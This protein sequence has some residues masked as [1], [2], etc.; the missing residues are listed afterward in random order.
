M[1]CDFFNMFF[2][3]FLRCPSGQVRDDDVDDDYDG[4]VMTMT[5]LIFIMSYARSWRFLFVHVVAY[6]F[7]CH[8]V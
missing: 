4:D 6:L 1:S 3:L 2:A 7:A 8:V 5:V